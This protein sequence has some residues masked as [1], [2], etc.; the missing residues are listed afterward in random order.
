V[1]TNVLSGVIFRLAWTAPGDASRTGVFEITGE[2]EAS[3]STL[4]ADEPNDVPINCDQC[5]Y[6]PLKF[7][8]SR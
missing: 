7:I 3:G 2:T 4:L 1:S 8:I 5:R 6:L